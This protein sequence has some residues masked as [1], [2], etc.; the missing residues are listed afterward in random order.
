[1]K[2]V[3]AGATGFIGRP[4]LQALAGA[5]HEVVQLTRRSGEDAS[6]PSGGRRV[7]WD[8]RTSDGN[9]AAELDGAGAVINLAGANIGEKRWTEQRKREILESRLDA[10]GA[11]VG[12]MAPVAAGSRPQVLVNASG[13]DYYGDRGDE[14][15]TE[16][17]PAGDSFLAGV[18]RQWETAAL[19]AEPLG[20]RVVLIRTAVVLAPGAIALQRLA[21]PFK[22]FA[23]GPLG[24]GR[25]WFSWIHLQ[26]AI[27]LYRLAVE[28]GQAN[29][30][31]N[32]VAPDVRPEREV[33]REVGK[34]LRR[35][36]WAPV[37]GFALKLALGEQ[38]DLVLHGRRAEPRKALALG[39][40]FHYPQLPQALTQALRD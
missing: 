21:F 5:G 32:A 36:S 38:A 22:L 3:M 14:V 37:P 30:P 24:S 2:I 35:P 23:G 33:A 17:S 31:L 15:V 34:V 11:I 9:W 4:L 25:Q 13:I 16:E 29:G 26:D 6:V 7:Q 19:K 8:G 40:A 1:M 10:T 39:Y 12:A 18:C 28:N 20:V 27:G